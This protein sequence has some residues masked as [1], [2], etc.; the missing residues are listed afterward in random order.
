[1]Q[2]W[3]YIRIPTGFLC[4]LVDRNPILFSSSK[5]ACGGEYGACEEVGAFFVC[6]VFTGGEGYVEPALNE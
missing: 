4:Y 6:W 2:D 5:S 3:P 1:M